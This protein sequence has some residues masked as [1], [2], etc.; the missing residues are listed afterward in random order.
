MFDY[1]PVHYT[2]A[3][4]LFSRLLGLI[5][6]IVYI[7]FL[8]QMKGL[9]GKNGICPIG[10][11][12]NNIFCRFGRR[13]YRYFPTI[14]WL[15]SSDWYQLVV[16]WSA[17]FC[18]LMLMVGIY[19]LVMLVILY[20]IHLSVTSAGQEFLSFGWE[21]FLLEATV[22]LFLTMATVPYNTIG[23]WALNLL[24]F[25][26]YFQAG[27]SKIM[28]GDAHWRDLTAIWYHYQT[29]PIPNCLSW[30][31]HKLPMWFHKTSCFFM[32]VTEL[33][34]SFF[35]FGTIEMRAISFF[36][37]AG[38]QIG[39]WLTGNFSYLNHLTMAFCV[40]LLPNEIYRPFLG[41]I[42]DSTAPITGMFWN[43]CITIVATLFLLLQM[44]A[45]FYPYYR[46]R[47]LGKVLEM[48]ESFHIAYPHGIFAV[49]T[50]KRYE[51]ILEA[52]LDAVSWEEFEFFYKPDKLSKRPRRVSPYQP[53]ID[54]QAWFLPFGKAYWERWFRFLLERVAVQ[55]P[56]VLALFKKTPVQNFRPLYLRAL[57]YDY[58]FTTFEEKQ[59]SGN[60]WKRTYIGVYQEPLSVIQP[61]DGDS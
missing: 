47:Y 27:T 46:H 58:E 38:L 56:S 54:W 1:T 10:S 61:S 35:I 49:M 16:V 20:V 19:P 50:T 30:Y 55:E 32:F 44:V 40:I 42:M 6:V 57:I 3:L 31:M 12:L 26:F 37:L 14:F 2:V 43:S 11:Y 9:F 24:F 51:V 53:R 23:W 17:I 5:Y 34:L 59:A 21:T 18:G 45:L 39:I 4:E 36:F 41:T 48:V 60:W 25:R 28:S 22:A 33:I 13:S 52:S 7:P 8:F 29:Q 15:N